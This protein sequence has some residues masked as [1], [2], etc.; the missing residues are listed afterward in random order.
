MN[1]SLK[2]EPLKSLLAISRY[3]LTRPIYPWSVYVAGILV[4]LT[5]TYSSAQTLHVAKN[6]N[7]Q[8][9]GT[10]SEPLRSIQIALNRAIAGDQ[11]S[12]RSG[13]YQENLRTQSSG[14]EVAPITLS[15][16]S[17]RSVTVTANSGNVLHIDHPFLIVENLIFDGQFSKNDVVRVRATGDGLIFRDNVVRNGAKDGM[18][19]GNAATV[20]PEQFDYLEDIQILDSEFEN[21]LAQNLFGQR[22][23]AHGIV[24]GGIHD[25]TIA[26]V[27]VSMVSGDALQLANGNWNRVEVKS[28]VFKNGPITSELADLTGFPVGINPGENAID[29]KQDISLSVRSNLKISDSTFQ[30]WSGDLISNAAALNLK[31]KVTVVI[32]SC[33]FS[34]NEIAMRLRGGGQTDD[35]AHISATNNIFH[36]N[37]K[38]IRLEDNLFGLALVNNTFGAGNGQFLQAV[39]GGAGAGFTAINNLFLA[40]TVPSEISSVVNMAVDESIFVDASSADYRLQPDVE[41]IDTAITLPEN[42]A[43]HIGTIRPQGGGYDFGA[44]EYL[45]GKKIPIPTWFAL[46]AIPAVL[47]FLGAGISKKH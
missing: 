10:M 17:D 33:S 43:D 24:A 19:L 35:G 16:Q 27:S 20:V 37:T 42:L 1:F 45:Q 2:I 47:I 22:I 41:A 21:F 26:R 11:I 12:I 18:D 23:D 25:L 30:G 38:A 7:D 40:P 32:E 9:P 5:G 31:E 28:V 14:T 29:T 34:D 13:T 6:G 3:P 44:F 15:G 39:N 8:N 46:I 4:L 36:A